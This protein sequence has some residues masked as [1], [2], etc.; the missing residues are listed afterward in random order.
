MRIHHGVDIVEIPRFQ[1][2]FE[3]H[4]RFA[5][6]VFTAQERAY[7]RGFRDRGLHFAGRFA[8]KEAC[9]KALGAGIPGP[10]VSHTF[11]EVE[12]L[13][14]S[15]GRPGLAVSGW[16]ARLAA[17]RGIR[18]W[19]VSIAHTRRYCVASVIGVGFGTDDEETQ[20]R[21]RRPCRDTPVRGRKAG[22]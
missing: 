5:E 9:L 12:I 17:S 2:V 4:E 14:G 7:C 3:R 8:A 19:S 10:G 11:Q 13:P 20:D 1:A 15:Q 6:E 21:R 16:T 18:R 22:G